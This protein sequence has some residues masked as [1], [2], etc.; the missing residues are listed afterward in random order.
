MR[1]PIA[2]ENLKCLARAKSFSRRANIGH[3]QWGETHAGLAVQQLRAPGPVCLVDGGVAGI[4]ARAHIEQPLAECLGREEVRHLLVAD[5]VCLCRLLRFR[6]EEAH[7]HD[8]V[9]GMAK[10]IF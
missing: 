3:G 4:A 5:G 2:K 10:F 9:V 1:E 6:V 7:V 8:G